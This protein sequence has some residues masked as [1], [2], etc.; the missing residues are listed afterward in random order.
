MA[1]GTRYAQFTGPE[2]DKLRFVRMSG[3]ESLG[4]LFA[5]EIDLVSETIDVDHNKML[6][7]E[8]TVT[9]KG[10]EGYERY[11][12]GIVT[13]FQQLEVSGRFCRYRLILR[14]WLWLLGN[15]HDCRIYQ[16]MS[17]VDIARQV[18]DDNGMADYEVQLSASYDVREYVVQYNESDLDFLRRWFE[19]EGIYFFFKHESGKHK[20]ILAD[21]S[22]AHGPDRN[23]GRLPYAAQD[24]APRFDHINSFT[25]VGAITPGAYVTTSFDFEAPG[26]ALQ[27]EKRAPADHANGHFEQFQFANHYTAKAEGSHYAGVRQERFIAERESASGSGDAAALIVGNTFKLENYPSDDLNKEYLIVGTDVELLGDDHQGGSDTEIEFVCR[28]TCMPASVAYRPQQVV[29]WPRVAG[30]QTAIVV[31]PSN[32]EIWTDEHGRIKVQFH[33]DRYGSRDDNSSCWIRVSQIHAGK[34]W[35]GIDIPRIGEE[36]IV[37]FVEGD[38][39]NPIVVGRVYNGDLRPP[40]KLPQNKSQTGIRS[41]TTKGGGGFNEL[42]F[43]D[44]KDE[45]QVFVHAQKDFETRIENNT[46]T[47]VGENLTLHIGADRT[48]EID[49]D[50]DQDV[51]GDRKLKVGGKVTIDAG[52]QITLKT[53]SSKLVMSANGTIAISGMQINI[54]GTKGVKAEGSLN[55]EVKGTM[56]KINGSAMTEVKAGGMTSVK[57]GLVKVN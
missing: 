31:G 48:V 18:F 2:D 25:K 3:T 41:N 37:S 46:E 33:W 27:A 52:Q 14:P 39:D 8:A 34:G 23:Y 13:Q 1:D 55:V 44:K 54:K 15:T 47:T 24:S 17:V 28:F 45:E 35:G 29:A 22:S 26:K 50:D 36:V 16:K 40:N 38:P 5:Y 42:R 32:E 57:G 56:V 19:R 30:P 51:G 11:L 7:R 9:Y 10:R 4:E 20:L 49:G 6:G 43:E 12:N 53:G 21:S